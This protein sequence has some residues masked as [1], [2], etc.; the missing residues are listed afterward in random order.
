VG[1]F[2]LLLEA[3]SSPAVVSDSEPA[4]Y[5]PCYRPQQEGPQESGCRHQG[6]FVVGGDR[7]PEV[8]DHRGKH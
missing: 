2:I 1:S 8:D 7:M 3:T 4:T 5:Q 6:T